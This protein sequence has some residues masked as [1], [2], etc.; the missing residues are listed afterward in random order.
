MLCPSRGR[1]D[2]AAELMRN[3]AKFAGFA[4]LVVIQD[5]DDLTS[6]PIGSED[7]RTTLLTM[8]SSLGRGSIGKALRGWPVYAAVTSDTHKADGIREPGIGP[9][10]NSV[11]A[12]LCADPSLDYIGFLGDDHRPRTPLWDAKLVK[13]I[14]NQER[15]EFRAV[16]VAYGDDLFQ[17]ENMPTACIMSADLVR[18][19]GVMN[20]PGC[21][22]L[23]LDNFWK[24]LG[25][26]VRN[27]KYVPEVIIEHLHPYAGKAEWDAGHRRV[28]S[29]SMQQHD[30]LA[31]MRFTGSE[32]AGMHGKI[33]AGL[34][35]RAEAL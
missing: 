9:L 33:L 3:W 16:G 7:D 10:V 26:S 25:Q 31:W 23:Y 11:A 19:A 29:D 20:P 35:A 17:G 21:T 15:G 32:W 34:R 14:E 4:R 22:H 2:A 1:P 6:Y 12:E 5:S 28:N 18:W 24:L 30:A 8:D 13:A 27:L